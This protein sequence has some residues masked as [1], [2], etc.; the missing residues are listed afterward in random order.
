MRKT[1]GTA[2]E[3][4]FH[5]ELQWAMHLRATPELVAALKGAVTGGA[6]SSIRFENNGDHV[7]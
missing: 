5:P 4:D 1:I 7:R 6:L 2:F 3:L